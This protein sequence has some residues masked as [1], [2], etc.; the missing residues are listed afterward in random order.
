M[1]SQAAYFRFQL[2]GGQVGGFGGRCA[3]CPGECFC[4][5]FDFSR[6]H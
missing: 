3:G 1:A 6:P 2:G 5:V 4:H